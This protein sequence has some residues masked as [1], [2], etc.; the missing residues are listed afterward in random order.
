VAASGS[1][2]YFPGGS[3]YYISITYVYPN[4]EE[5]IASAYSSGVAPTVGQNI[6]VTAPSNPGNGAIG[7]RCFISQAGNSS[8]NYRCYDANTGAVPFGTNATINYPTNNNAVGWLE[9]PFASGSSQ[10]VIWG[11]AVFGGTAVGG[12]G[13]GEGGSTNLS[14]NGGSFVQPATNGG[15][16]FAPN[17][18]LCLPPNG[19]QISWGLWGDS[20]LDGTGDNGFGGSTSGVGYFARALMNQLSLQ[21][22]PAIIPS[23]GYTQCSVGG[24]TALACASNQGLS[25]AMIAGLNPY[26]VTDLGTNDLSTGAAPIVN[27]LITFGQRFTTVGKKFFH[28]GLIP[29]GGSSDAYTTI[30]NQTMTVGGASEATRREVNNWLN[31]TKAQG[32]QFTAQFGFGNGS[33]TTFYF[34]FPI[35]SQSYSITVGGAPAVYNASP[36]TSLQYSE[37]G[38]TTIN[39]SSYVTGITFGAATASPAPLILTSATSPS[40]PMMKQFAGS[41]GPSAT[42]YGVGDGSATVFYFNHPILSGSESITNGGNACTYNASPSTQTQY[43]YLY[44][45]SIG[46]STYVSGVTFGAAPT[47]NNG[48]T[49]TGTKI[50]GMA[51][52]L[53]PNATFLNGPI[54]FGELN[55]SGLLQMNGGFCPLAQTPV[56][57]TIGSP[58]SLTATSSNGFTDTSLS[59]L[60]QD[61]YAGYCV[62]IIADSVTPTAVGQTQCIGTNTTADVFTCGSWTVQPSTSAKYVILLSPMQTATHPSSYGHMNYASALRTNYPSL[63]PY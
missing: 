51:S 62:S 55:G 6:V 47:N 42:F 45:Q 41:A 49:Y 36:S 60:T 14:V 34:P 3:T 8:T 50:A 16:A 18:I 2:S 27:S 54:C 7:Y 39:G 4:G 9:G 52:Y 15:N 33:S 10:S 19:S 12:R 58:H 40:L 59:T 46:G 31:D 35:V 24:D 28:T 23:Y 38:A 53:G 21:Y 29:R 61:Q 32:G 22:N 20:I 63:F 5:S 30:T 56:V 37:V 44:S 48:I 43:N 25:R 11:S 26:V 57:G 1:G 17:A 13:S